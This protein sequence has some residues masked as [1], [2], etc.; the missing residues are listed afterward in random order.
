MVYY[1]FEND[2]IVST[3]NFIGG[4]TSFVSKGIKHAET[5]WDL[6]A[7]LTIASYGEQNV[8]LCLGYDYSGR[9]DFD[10]HS[11]TGKVR[12]EF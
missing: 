2:S 4:N 8:S 3:S 5:S 11:V 9:Q 10:S 1:D 7:A 12:F 6:G